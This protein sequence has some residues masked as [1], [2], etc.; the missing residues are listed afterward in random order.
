MYK[1]RDEDFIKNFR[2]DSDVRKKNAKLKDQAA[3]NNA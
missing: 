2:A 1:N 3:K